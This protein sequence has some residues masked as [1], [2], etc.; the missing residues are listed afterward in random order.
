MR[1]R[2]S[3]VLLLGMVTVLLGA[4]SSAG[5][6]ATGRVSLPTGRSATTGR[7]AHG[8]SKPAAPAG[9]PTAHH[10]DGRP[11]VGALSPPG[12]SI[13]VCTASVVDSR[14]GNLVLTAAHCIVGTGKGYVFAP[15]SH[16][17]VLPLQPSDR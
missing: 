16:D 8:S 2:V 4:C 7:A 13:H 11:S 15:G 12:L 5:P 10:F 3:T 9:T 1:A 14:S 17:G 6:T